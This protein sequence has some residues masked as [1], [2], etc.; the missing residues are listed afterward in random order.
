MPTDRLVKG[1]FT[2][3]VFLFSIIISTSIIILPFTEALTSSMTTSSNN[4]LMSVLK[5]TF[6]HLVSYESTKTISQANAEG[7]RLVLTLHEEEANAPYDHAVFVKRVVA[8]DYIGTKKDWADLRRTLL[9]MRTEVR[10]YKE[11]L[12]V[13]Q[14]TL[15]GAND[16]PST[17]TTTSSIAPKIHLAQHSLEKFI[18]DDESGLAPAG[19]PP[20]IYEEYQRDPTILPAGS[21][22]IIMDCVSDA[23]Y[24]QA[25]PISIDQ[26]KQ[27]LTAVAQLHAAA[28]ENQPLLEQCTQR[29]SLAS[30]HLQVRNPKELA[31]MEASWEHFS[32]QFATALDEAGLSERTKTLGARIQQAAKAISQQLSPQYNEPYATLIHGDYKAMNV[33]LPKDPSTN[34]NALLVDFASTGIGLGVSDVA[35]HIHHAVIPADLANG[36]EEALV[37]HYWQELDKLLQERGKNYPRDVAMKQYRLAVIDYGRF[38][39]GRFWK[40][41]TPETFAKRKDSPNTT[42]IN[43]NVEAAMAFIDRMERYLTE[44]EQ[45]QATAKKS[46]L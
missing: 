35:M 37:D 45:E 6:P 16:S 4:D 25:S 46:E 18:P 22:E 39:L 29:L 13:L 40:T 34:N 8:S 36:G 14:K 43:R 7:Q 17:S 28:W 44:F 41:A 30:F 32:T 23:D 21:G 27:C 2:T 24:F 9:Y 26:A 15:L 11:I 12:P 31:G 5:E 19:A 38:V 1:I 10:F 3:R 33:F 42:L 20:A